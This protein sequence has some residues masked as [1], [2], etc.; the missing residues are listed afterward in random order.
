MKINGFDAIVCNYDNINENVV[1]FEKFL[2]DNMYV[3]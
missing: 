2:T 1:I 3:F